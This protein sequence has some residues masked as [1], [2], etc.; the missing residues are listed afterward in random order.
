MRNEAKSALDSQ[1]AALS[2]IAVLP[3]PT[4]QPE[5]PL[6]IIS[7]DIASE[8]DCQA[9]EI[10]IYES[11][12]LADFTPDSFDSYRLRWPKVICA[13][14]SD[15]FLPALTFLA[16]MSEA[17]PGGLNPRV[18]QPITFAGEPI[19][20]LIPINS[21]LLQYFTAEELRDR[22]QYR[23]L[24]SSDSPKL[25]VAIELLLTGR[26]GSQQPEPY[27]LTYVYPLLQE[28]A[29][30]VAPVLELWPYI[31]SDNWSAYYGL[32]FDFGVE[33]LT[34]RPNFHD[35]VEVE[36]FSDDQGGR[37]SLTR[38]DK[39]PSYVECIGTDDK[40]VG[41]I[42]LTPPP[43]ISSDQE[44]RIGVDFNTQSTNLQIKRL[45]KIEPISIHMED[46]LL[47]IV[48][49]PIDTRFPTL[50]SI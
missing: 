45:G 15:I 25:E 42:L 8:W 11:T 5:K 50:Y 29:L 13:T 18:T 37:Y 35:Q 36:Q 46:L 49:S 27:R 4:K 12:T 14:P 23:L 1:N 47:K 28:N 44:W 19:T 48:D 3:S 26:I 32:F 33:E 22:I 34:F 7:P 38:M 31:Q 16:H 20:P 30:D 9:A 10:Q 21:L 39:F 17:I 6:L 24:E 41:L 40:I 2:Q 43:F